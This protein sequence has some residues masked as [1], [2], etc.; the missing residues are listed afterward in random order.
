MAIPTTSQAASLGGASAGFVISGASTNPIV[1]KIG[2]GCLYGWAITNTNAAIRYVCFH[3][4]NRNPVAGQDVWFKL[5][6]PAS[7]MANVFSPTGIQFQSGLAITTV[8]NP[9]LLDATSV[10]A[11]D[12]VV[13]VFYN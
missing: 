13:T 9:A 4:Q 2:S 12:L 6:I 3:D 1:I 5:G 7:G 10:A 8:V 11:N